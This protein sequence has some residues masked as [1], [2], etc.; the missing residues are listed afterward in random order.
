MSTP[1]LALVAFVAAFALAS[2]T[3]ASNRAPSAKPAPVTAA[4]CTDA[5]GY[6][7]PYTCAYALARAQSASL[8][9]GG[10]D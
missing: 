9:N 1:R 3:L 8:Y 7:G 2:L 5:P 10:R 6:T 4:T